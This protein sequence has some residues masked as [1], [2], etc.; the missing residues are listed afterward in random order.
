MNLERYAESA[1]VL[2]STVFSP[3]LVVCYAVAALFPSIG[4][5][6]L[7]AALIIA[8]FVVPPV[9][10][11]LFLMRKGAVSSFHLSEHRERFRPLRFIVLNTAAGGILFG[12]L[13]GSVLLVDVVVACLAALLAV[14]F[15]T[16]YYKISAHTAALSSLW[17]LLSLFYGTAGTA[18][19]VFLP[20]LSWARVRLSVHTPLQTIAGCFLGAAVTF[21]VLKIKG[22]F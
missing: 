16:L 11:I 12:F 21:A 20:V 10:Y 17:V 7:L 15:A 22:H 6:F 14:Y 9:F 4:G 13:G 18:F 2:A 5:N 3:P 1:A 8:V 19:A